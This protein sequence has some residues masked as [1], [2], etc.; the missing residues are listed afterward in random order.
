VV[1]D[2]LARTFSVGAIDPQASALLASHPAAPEKA[3][4]ALDVG[5]LSRYER[6]SL[7]STLM[8]RSLK[9]VATK[10]SDGALEAT[11]KAGYKEPHK[12]TIAAR[13]R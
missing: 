5:E 10:A 11:I 3:E 4:L 7:T 13:T 6:P 1:A 9:G 12:P 2:A 8:R